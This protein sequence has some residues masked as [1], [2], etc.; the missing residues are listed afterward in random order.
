MYRYQEAKIALMAVNPYT[1]GAITDAYPQLKELAKNKG[2]SLTD[3]NKYFR[4]LSF[5]FDIHSPM[6]LEHPDLQERRK[7]ASTETGYE[8]AGDPAIEH[9]FIS[10]IVRSRM[11]TMYCCLQ[12]TFDDF[13]ERVSQK[14]E[15]DPNNAE[16]AM[17]AEERR[18]KLL[19]GMTEIE[20]EMAKYSM[21]LWEGDVSLEEAA[22][23]EITNFSP[24]NLVN[25]GS[26]K[27]K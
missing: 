16:T 14:I 23:E 15:G 7:A 22:E 9:L 25:I 12:K 8:G 5:I 3:L 1:K 6:V 2:I 24:E 21:R 13:A 20:P 26:K 11:W 17:K 18:L 10:R 19:K 4:Y 27:K